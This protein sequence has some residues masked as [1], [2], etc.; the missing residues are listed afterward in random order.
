[1]KQLLTFT[2][3]LLLN[4]HFFAQDEREDISGIVNSFNTPIENVHIVNTNTGQGTISNSNGEFIIMVKVDDTLKFTHLEYHL[5]TL[6]IDKK[7]IQNPLIISLQKVVNQIPEVVVKNHNLSGLLVTD[8]KNETS[9]EIEAK[10]KF[11]NEL[12]EL[13]K[14]PSKKDSDVNYEKP[15][16]NDVSTIKFTGTPIGINIPDKENELR[17]ALRIKKSIPDKIIQDLGEDYFI[18]EL[19]IPKDS[20]HNFLTYCN[21]KGIFELYKKGDILK[22]I[23][24]LKKEAK[25]YKS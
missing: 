10:Y 6:K 11:Q 19:K 17:R 25:E 15:Y 3:I 1:M 20:I 14:L 24:I 16:L 7:T 8:S 12:M 5:F 13:A 9:E 23:D 4:F 21:F 18:N 22:L 2:F